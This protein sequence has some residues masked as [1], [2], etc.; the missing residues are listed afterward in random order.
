MQ[1]GIQ[2]DCDPVGLSG[3]VVG[4]CYV[5]KNLG[6]ACVCPGAVP[7][8]GSCSTTSECAPGN[9]CAGTEPPGVC[10]P[11]CDPDA[12]DCAARIVD[13]YGEICRASDDSQVSLPL[14]DGDEVRVPPFLVKSV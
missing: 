7:T 4:Q 14:A 10:R 6:S 3:C 9:V 12:A 8:G 2:V 1:G 13:L 5:L 11:T